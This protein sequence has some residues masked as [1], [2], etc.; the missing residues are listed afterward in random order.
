M[1]E[2]GREVKRER[3]REREKVHT[4]VFF[5]CLH[6]ICFF[7]HCQHGQAS[8]NLAKNVQLQKVTFLLSGKL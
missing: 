5:C 8:K 3:E 4:Y 6:A 7:K 1:R 2:R